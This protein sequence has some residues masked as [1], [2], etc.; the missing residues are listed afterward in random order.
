MKHNADRTFRHAEVLGHLAGALS[1]DRN[2]DHDVALPP[3]E[4]RHGCL[5]IQPAGEG[6]GRVGNEQVGELVDRNVLPPPA[7]APEMID[8]FVVGYGPNPWQQR[9]VLD[10]RMPLQVHGQQRLLYDVLDILIGKAI[11]QKCVSREAAQHRANFAKQLAVRLRVTAVGGTHKLGKVHLAQRHVLIPYSD[12]AVP[13]L[14]IRQK[15]LATHN[16]VKSVTLTPVP[17]NSP[18][19][20]PVMGDLRELSH[21]Q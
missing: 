11:A 7:R 3:L 12:V 6:R 10:P 16:S 13:A 18:K 9:P 21:I 14:Q 5:S 20:R 2:S 4:F 1:V 19:S 17:A 15:N 8:K